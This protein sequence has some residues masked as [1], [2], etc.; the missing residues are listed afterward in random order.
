MT[1][2]H[3][4]GGQGYCQIPFNERTVSDSGS[5]L[6]TTIALV[7]MCEQEGLQTGMHGGSGPV[8]CYKYVLFFIPCCI[9]AL[10]AHSSQG[11]LVECSRLNPAKA[12]V[13]KQLPDYSRL[14]FYSDTLWRKLK[15]P[16]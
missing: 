14:R 7:R 11:T 16:C 2:I 4:N 15:Q 8:T 12:S 9:P 5:L 1:L 13:A 3:H 10:L 6:M